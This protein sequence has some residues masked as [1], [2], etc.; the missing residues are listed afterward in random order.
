[1]HHAHSALADF[2]GEFA[3]FVHGSIFSRVGASSKPGAVHR[4]CLNPDNNGLAKA[5]IAAQPLD[6][7][8][9][10]RL[11]EVLYRKKKPMTFLSKTLLRVQ[12]PSI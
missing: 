8:A 10:A 5:L 4:A 9:G 3:R 2:R 1:L 6:P 11:A 7:H 12:S